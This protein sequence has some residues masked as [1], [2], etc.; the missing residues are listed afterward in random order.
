M[1]FQIERGISQYLLT[2]T[3]INVCLGIVIGTG[4]WLIGMPNPVLWGVMAGCLNFMPYIG[5]FVGSGV[6]FL[7]AALSFDSM[8]QALLAPAIYAAANTIEGNVI[9]PLILGRSMR[10]NP[11]FIFLSVVLWGWMWGVGGALIAVPLL[12]MTK[13]ACAHSR[14]LQSVATLLES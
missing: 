14:R 12:A 3:A 4:M 8:G 13:I 6:V 2:F 10:L 9:T 1:F 5:A 7:V 11:I